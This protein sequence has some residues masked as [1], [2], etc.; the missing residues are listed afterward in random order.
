MRRIQAATVTLCA[1]VATVLGG[2]TAQA[3]GPGNSD[4]AHM[5]LDGPQ[6]DEYYVD[7]QPGSEANVD[8][9]SLAHGVG[10]IDGVPILIAEGSAWVETHSHG[11]CVS[12]FAAAKKGTG[13]GGGKP[14]PKD[15]VFTHTYDKSSPILL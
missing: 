12:F 15:I 5:C 13:S 7:G 11:Q 1:T 4:A 14:K 2:G 10:P 6:I 9:G 3:V 8:F